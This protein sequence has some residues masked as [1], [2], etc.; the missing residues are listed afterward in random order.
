MNFSDHNSYFSSSQTGF[1]VFISC[2]QR[3]GGKG[4]ST[5]LNIINASKNLANC[6]LSCGWQCFCNTGKLLPSY[7]ILVLMEDPVYVY[8]AFCLYNIIKRKLPLKKKT[9]KDSSC[10][11]LKITDFQGICHCM[12]EYRLGEKYSGFVV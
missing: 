7:L 1:I 9:T 12:N 5:H 2:S 10:S 11:D 3:F 8:I 6:N 4:D